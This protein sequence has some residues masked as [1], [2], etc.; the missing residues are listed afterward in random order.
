MMKDV[1]VLGPGC[2]NCQRLAAL[3]QKVS[4][5]EGLPAAVEKVTDYAEIMRY[6]VM[7]TP[8]LVVDGQLVVSGRL[9]SEEE[10]RG[11]LVS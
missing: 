6:G 11:W 2:A 5:A 9:P 4:D 3:V 1:K 8:G 10:I 7:R